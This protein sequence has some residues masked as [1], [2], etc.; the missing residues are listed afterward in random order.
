VLF[1]GI[2]VGEVKSLRLDPQIPQRVTATISVERLTP[3]RTDTKIEIY[4]QGLMGSPAISLMGGTTSAP[5]PSPTAT[6]PPLLV[7]DPNAGQDMMQAAREA[8]RRLDNVL[9]ENAEP[10]RDTIGNLKSF[11]DALARNSERVDAIAKGL[12][13]MV[14]GG[15][16]VSP[17]IYD[18]VAP[19]DFPPLAKTPDTQL[20]VEEPTA[21]LALDTQKVLVRSNKVE[22][23]AFP[24]TQWS[25]SLPKL[26]LSRIIQSFENAG[27]GKVSRDVPGLNANF[28]LLVD[29]R[30]VHVI[31][32]PSPLA[33][34]EFGA[35]VLAEDGRIIDTRTFRATAAAK[36]INASSATAAINDAFGKSVVD[37]V[38][39]TIGVV[40]T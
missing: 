12:E 24:D 18:L 23:G 9:V 27:Y 14:G 11:T 36:E 25:D 33:E 15:E 39:W 34:V 7:A 35:K 40:G 22:G 1:N 2:R 13:R 3:I 20:V 28:R 30:N 37:L 6:E 16:K 19:K 31:G 26:F 10:L 17:A 4:T 32:E 38:R 5:A 29:I 8:L 21:V